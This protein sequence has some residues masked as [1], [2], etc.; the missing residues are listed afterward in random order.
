[1]TS[2]F[3]E[4]SEN[5]EHLYATQIGYFAYRWKSVWERI[6]EFRLSDGFKPRQLLRAGSNVPD[7]SEMQKSA[8]TDGRNHLRRCRHRRRRACQ[9]RAHDDDISTRRPSQGCKHACGDF[10]VFRKTANKPDLEVLSP[11]ANL[12]YTVAIVPRTFAAFGRLHG[13]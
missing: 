6:L 11:R 1:M 12:R 5:A 8:K 3:D 13:K 4:V 7:R 9:A 10:L 2:N